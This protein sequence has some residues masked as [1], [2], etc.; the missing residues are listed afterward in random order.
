MIKAA[1]GFQLQKMAGVV[2]GITFGLCG[3]MKFRFTD[4][5]LTI[6]AIA[7]ISKNFLMIDKGGNGKSQG[8]MAGLAHITGSDMIRQFS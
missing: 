3:L 1:V 6:M 4:G 7:A 8:G 2:A 5:Q